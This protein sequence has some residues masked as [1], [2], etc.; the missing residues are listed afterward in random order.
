MLEPV[1][2][3]SMLGESNIENERTVQGHLLLSLPRE[4]AMVT[5]LFPPMISISTPCTASL[6]PRRGKKP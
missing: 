2:N 5:A 4:E 3:Q 1:F 6:Q